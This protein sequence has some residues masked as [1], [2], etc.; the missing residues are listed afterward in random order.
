MNN[1]A[2]HVNLVAV[3]GVSGSLGLQAELRQDASPV[4]HGCRFRVTCVKAQGNGRVRL[5][6]SENPQRERVWRGLLYQQAPARCLNIDLTILRQ[7]THA[8]HHAGPARGLPRLA[9]QEQ[10]RLQ[11]AYAHDGRHG[12]E[13]SA[14]MRATT[15]H[16]HH[17]PGLQQQRRREQER[18]AR[19]QQQQQTG[20]A[21]SF[22][23]VRQ[24][25][26]WRSSRGL[27]KD[28]GEGGASSHL[29][30]HLHHRRR[31]RRKL[32]IR[33]IGRVQRNQITYER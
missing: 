30:C 18:L 31:H 8:R 21:T 12:N 23:S 25:G 17:Y 24:T 9:E 26:T 16:H 7:S 27:G 22:Q 10:E 4:R 19:Q 1:Q 15:R 33:C 14:S 28:K 29:L 3:V 32:G 11:A 2:T 5:R 13:L 6:V 20:T